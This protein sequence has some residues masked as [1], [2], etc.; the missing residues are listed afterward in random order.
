MKFD[1]VYPIL[2]RRASPERGSDPA[3]KTRRR[4]RVVNAVPASAKAVKENEMELKNGTRKRV[5]ANLKKVGR[6]V[7]NEATVRLAAN[8]SMKTSINQM[9]S[10]RLTA[11]CQSVKVYR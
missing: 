1:G 9:N 10:P 7:A 4:V 5:G 11:N 2:A 6:Q 3:A 8:Q